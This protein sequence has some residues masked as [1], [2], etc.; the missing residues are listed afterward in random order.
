MNILLS[1][2]KT[3]DL[4]EYNSHNLN[5]TVP[6]FE[7]KTKK[8]V[9]LLR[10]YKVN[11]LGELMHLSPALATLNVDRYKAFEFP[12]SERVTDFY[13]AAKAFNGEVYKGLD[14]NTLSEIEQQRAQSQVLIL[15][16]LYGV[17]RPMDLIYPYR[18]EMGTRI[19]IDENTKNLYSYW[20]KELT[21]HVSKEPFNELLNLA[22]TE[23]SKAVDFQKI[24]KRIVTPVFKEFKGGTYKVVMM[25][26]KHARG[27]MAR[28]II[29][30]NLTSV[31]DLKGYQEDGYS[32]TESLSNDQEWVFVR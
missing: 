18:L 25:Y 24:K 22:S 28:Y 9:R 2:A 12:N 13:P 4:T 30:E 15:S 3:I 23:Y 27:R 16:G 6:V 26:A 8:L 29:Q 11:E 7:S 21:K 20:Q 1:P 5:P 31:D 10:K 32:Y 17:L 14:F 19:Q